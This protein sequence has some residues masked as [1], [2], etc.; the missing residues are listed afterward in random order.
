MI[1][2]PPPAAAPG[3]LLLLWG[4]MVMA[5][6]VAWQSISV[7]AFESHLSASFASALCC[8]LAGVAL[9]KPER[10][11]CLYLGCGIALLGAS[12][13]GEYLAPGTVGIDWPALPAWRPDAD[14]T[15]RVGRPQDIAQSADSTIR[16]IVAGNALGF[17]ILV[18]SLWMLLDSLIENI[19]N[20]IF[21]KDAVEVRGSL[22]GDEHRYSGRDNGVGFDMAYSGK[23]FGVFQRLHRAD[24]FGGSGVGLAIVQRAILRDGGRVW[25]EGKVNEGAMFHFTLPVKDIDERH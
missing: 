17:G 4:L 11:T 7:A 22:D 20:M 19:P 10:R 14:P 18:S 3:C 23:L 2:R 13:L 24:E 5:G 6:W 12:V 9:L 8:A 16:V 1:L 25:A 15:L 21:V